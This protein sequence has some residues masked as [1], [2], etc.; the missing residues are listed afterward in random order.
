MLSCSERSW[1]GSGARGLCVVLLQAR[2]EDV[3]LVPALQLSCTLHMLGLRCMCECTAAMSVL[4]VCVC[5]GHVCVAHMCAC[6]AAVA[7]LHAL[8]ML[9]VVCAPAQHVCQY[10]SLSVRL[11]SM[12]INAC[13]CLCACASCVWTTCVWPTCAC[14][15]SSAQHVCGPHVCGPHVCGPHVSVPHV[16]VPHVCACSAA[17]VLLHALAMLVVVCLWPI[18]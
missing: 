14:I 15:C 10:L 8:S 3:A 17:V 1:C 18:R 2:L 7:L 11:R 16:S 9:V 13:R 5:A 4:P 12:C 6:S